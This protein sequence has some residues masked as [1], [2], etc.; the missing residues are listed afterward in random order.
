MGGGCHQCGPAAIF[1]F[2]V[3]FG[4]PGRGEVECRAVVLAVGQKAA[5]GLEIGRIISQ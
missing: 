3:R 2:K 5:R 4:E 1:R